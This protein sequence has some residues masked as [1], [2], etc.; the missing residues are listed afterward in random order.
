MKRTLATV[1]LSFLMGV[2]VL[3]RGAEPSPTAKAE[4][5]HLFSRLEASGCEFN[6]NGTWYKPQDASVHLKK[7]YQYLLDKGM[8]T[9]AESFIEKAA[10]ESSASGK[11]YQVRCGGGA[12]ADSAVWFKAELTRHRSANNK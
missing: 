12:P 2:P 7:K 6:R 9:S 1:L 3:A 4:I 5:A 11:P 8:V 10:T